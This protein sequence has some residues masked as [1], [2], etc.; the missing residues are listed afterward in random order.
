MLQASILHRQTVHQHSFLV[1]G[2]GLAHPEPV[3]WKYEQYLSHQ[4]H[5]K[6]YAGRREV[7]MG[8]TGT[9]KNQALWLID[10]LKYLF[11]LHIAEEFRFSGIKILLLLPGDT[12][13]L[14]G[15]S[16]NNKTGAEMI[17]LPLSSLSGSGYPSRFQTAAGSA[18]GSAVRCQA[19]N[20]ESIRGRYL[21]Y[22]RCQGIL[23]NI[24]IVKRLI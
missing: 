4:L 3:L 14:P 18:A 20:I 7:S 2:H 24:F 8:V 12:A 10:L 9:K 5:P 21:T 23:G 1:A 22:C 19:C 13:F 11:R 17:F 16:R 6:L 15:N